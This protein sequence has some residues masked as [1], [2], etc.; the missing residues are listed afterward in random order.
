MTMRPAGP[1]LVACV[2]RLA[3]THEEEPSAVA[4]MGPRVHRC[5]TGAKAELVPPVAVR[6]PD[7]TRDGEVVTLPRGRTMGRH[8]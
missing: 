4:D 5:T 6:R 1:T 2:H 8:L 3:G 7:D